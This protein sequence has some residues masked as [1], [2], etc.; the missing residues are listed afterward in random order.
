[1]HYIPIT[2]ASLT[3]LSMI[4]EYNIVVITNLLTSGIWIYYLE[5]TKRD[6]LKYYKS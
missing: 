4:F 3:V 2:G 5:K 1:M 6:F